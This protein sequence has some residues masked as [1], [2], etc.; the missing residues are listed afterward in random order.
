MSY[1]D[2]LP[3]IGEYNPCMPDVEQIW[4][5][6]GYTEVGLWGSPVIVDGKVYLPTDEAGYFLACHQLA[7]TG[8]GHPR[9][10]TNNKHKTIGIV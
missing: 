10:S 8:M 4:Q 7:A 1:Y 3:E 6:D 9:F 2:N 5:Y